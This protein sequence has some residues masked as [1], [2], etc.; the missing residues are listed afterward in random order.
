MLMKKNNNLL[1]NLTKGLNQLSISLFSVFLVFLLVW[2]LLLAFSKY[3]GAELFRV[4]FYNPFV[5]SKRMKQI[6]LVF[7][8]FTVGAL[9]V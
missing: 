6:L 4:F 9:A 2:L 3:D 5:N 7:A 1:T 8:P